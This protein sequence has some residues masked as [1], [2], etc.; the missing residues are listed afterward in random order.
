MA[1]SL[2]ENLERVHVA[3]R[4]QQCIDDILDEAKPRKRQRPSAQSI[5]AN[6]EKDFLTPPTTF[7]PEWLDRLQH[8][9]ETTTNYNELFTLA[10]TQTRTVIRF[11]REGLG[12]HVTGY[13]EVTV[14]A[15]SA[16]A[17][18]STSILRKPA[19]RAD[20]VRGAAGFFPFAPGTF[21][22]ANGLSSIGS[23]DVTVHSPDGIR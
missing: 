11:S 16:T 21:F 5:K 17:K 14:P 20:F 1:D 13:K 8:R 18:N 10:P 22:P 3:S 6:L 23:L 15:N 9:W 19:N 7:S 12:G 2:T 4:D